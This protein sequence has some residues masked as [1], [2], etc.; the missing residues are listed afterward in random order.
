MIYGSVGSVSIIGHS[1]RSNSAV[2]STP[3][4]MHKVVG[5]FLMKKSLPLHQSVNAKISTKYGEK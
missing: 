2:S 3:G 1:R 5:K 4:C